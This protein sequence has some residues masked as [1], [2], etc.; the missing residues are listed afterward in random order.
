[1]TYR[2]F[3]VII[4]QAS[5]AAT[6]T[7]SNLSNNTGLTLAAF[8]PVKLNTSGQLELLDVSI[9]TD[10]LAF[11]GVTENAIPNSSDGSVISQGK[12]SNIGM[13]SFGDYVYVSKTSGLTNVLPSEGI[14]G[15]V[16]GDFIIRVGVIAKN[17][18]NPLDKDLFINSQIVGQI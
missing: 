5:G 7:R 18:A 9:E 14:S 16:A 15:F 3:S 10:A 6:A 4:T 8:T 13:F 17:E 11:V 2:P 1:M 12:L